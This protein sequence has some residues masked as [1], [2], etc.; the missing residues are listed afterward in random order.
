LVEFNKLTLA[1]VGV[2][3]HIDHPVAFHLVYD[4]PSLLAGESEPWGYILDL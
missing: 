3:N 4:I 1:V 2:I